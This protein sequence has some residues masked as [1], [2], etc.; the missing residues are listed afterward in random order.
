MQIPVRVNHCK[1]QWGLLVKGTKEV[2]SHFFLQIPHFKV[3][4]FFLKANWNEL[5]ISVAQFCSRSLADILTFLWPIF[6]IHT[7][8]KS[9][10]DLWWWNTTKMTTV[11]Y[12]SLG[13]N[14]VE[15]SS[16]YLHFDIPCSQSRRRTRLLFQYPRVCPLSVWTQKH[17]MRACDLCLLP[18]HFPWC[19]GIEA[20]WA[21]A[22]K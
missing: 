20:C 12:T 21:N 3:W 7:I 8:A 11:D 19:I 22:K 5:N 10:T 1:A 16:I 15:D 17:F 13:C 4:V 9:G 2:K 6:L 18:T 14:D